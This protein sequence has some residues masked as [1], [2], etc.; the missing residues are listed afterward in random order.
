M[1]EKKITELKTKLE[2]SQN[3]TTNG[4]LSVSV[5][6]F[7]TATSQFS[8]VVIYKCNAFFRT[9]SRQTALRRSR[10]LSRSSA[11]PSRSSSSKVRE[12]LNV[13]CF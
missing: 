5:R 9:F 13:V 1:L 2:S 3:E 4:R 7:L 10:S 8:N 6:D 11:R 12:R